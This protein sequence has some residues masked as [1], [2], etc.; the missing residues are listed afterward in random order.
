MA[1][2]VAGGQFID[3]EIRIFPRQ[4]KG[5]TVEVI[6][7]GEQHSPRGHLDATILPWMPSPDSVADDQQLVI[8]L[9]ADYLHRLL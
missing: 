6:L 4:D 9:F 8:S 1:N 7:G 2:H 5:C 3:L